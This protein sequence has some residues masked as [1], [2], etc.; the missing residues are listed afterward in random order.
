MGLQTASSVRGESL[1]TLLSL[2]ASLTW[3]A[4]AAVIAWSLAGLLMDPE[5]L[6]PVVMAA[7]FFALALLRAGFST[8]ADRCLAEAADARIDVLRQEIAT[9]E[10]QSTQPSALGGPGAL[11]AHR[12]RIAR[13]T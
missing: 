11:A 8:M 13:Q 2:A 9:V 7:C 4:A 5:A 6:S 10:A 1:G 12:S 3:L